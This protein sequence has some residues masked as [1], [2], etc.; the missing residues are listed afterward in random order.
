[1]SCGAAIGSV[2]VCVCNILQ[3]FTKYNIYN[4]LTKLFHRNYKILWQNA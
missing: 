2:C 4:I 3:P 1:M